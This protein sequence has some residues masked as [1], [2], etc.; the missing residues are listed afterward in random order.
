V[1]GV[2]AEPLQRHLRE[3]EWHLRGL[4]QGQRRSRRRR[5]LQGVCADCDPTINPGAYDYPGNGI[6]EDCSGVADDAPATCD[7]GLAL[8]SGQAGDFAKALELCKTT[9]ANATGAAKTWGVISSALVQA[10]GA[11]APNALSYGILSQFGT[12]NLPQKGARMAAFSS[13]TA[14]APSDTGWFNPNGQS[15]AQQGFNAGKSCAYPTGFP[16]NKVG[17]ANPVGLANDSAGLVMSI[18]VPTNASSFTYRFDF[19]TSEYPEYVCTAYNDSYVALLQSAFLPANPA[20]NSKNISFDA[21]SNPVNVNIGFFT[22]VSGPQLAATGFDGLCKDVKSPFALQTCGGGTGWLQTSA[23]VVPGETI[24]MQF[25]IWDASDHIWDSIVLVD[26]WVWS[27]SPATISTSVPPPPPVAIYS[28]GDFVRD[29]DATGVCPP[30]W[31]P[32][33]GLWSWN[34]HTPSDSS[35]SFSV[36]AAASVAGLGSAPVD[37]LRFSN[38]PGPVALAGQPVVAASSGSTN[39]GSAVVDTTLDASGRIRNLPALR[40]T[41]HLSPSTDKLSAPVL[42]AWDLQ[43]DC[44]PLQ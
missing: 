41:S 28:P 3:P 34:S 5:L 9:A 30:D 22:V 2:R 16:K 10:D 18:R 39:A 1:R 20:S 12:S 26:D 19:F 7:S 29:Y 36:Q 24:K 8:A 11:S 14:R 27:G 25:A 17:C 31:G 40:I 42:N 38:P 4:L 43:L 6:D 15:S 32:V 35:I 44:Q 23:P 37:A 33:W 21:N 13:G